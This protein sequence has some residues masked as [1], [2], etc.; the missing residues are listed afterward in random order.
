MVLYFG[1]V[2][3]GLE[4]VDE[5]ANAERDYNDMPLEPQVMVEVTVDTF[6]VDYPE[7]KKC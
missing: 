2:T 5:I 4:V 1:K 7:P 3:D 6:G